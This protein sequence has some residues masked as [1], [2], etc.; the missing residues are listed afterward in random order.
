MSHKRNWKLWP[1]KF[2][3]ELN[4]VGGVTSIGGTIMTVAGFG[5]LA[6]PVGLFIG[7][8]GAVVAT[9]TVFYAGYRAIPEQLLNADKLVGQ[10]FRLNELDKFYPPIK[11]LAII[12]PQGSG[13]TTLKSNLAFETINR[14]RTQSIIAQV[15]SIPDSPASH[16]LAVLDGAGEWFGQQFDLAKNAEFVCIMLDHNVSDSENKLS[17]QRLEQNRIFLDQVRKEI[18]TNN[19]VAKK[20]IKFLINKQDLWERFTP[21]QKLKFDTFCQDVLNTWKA[22]NLAEEVDMYNHSNE[23]T[24]DTTKFMNILKTTLR[25]N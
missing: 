18:S 16:H 1:K 12:G 15:V 13:K 25:T 5:A 7:C 17:S 19:I 21:A 9:G 22:S 23:R 6:G 8:L 3:E 20:W 11:K 14:L 4:G 24:G 10:T 2:G